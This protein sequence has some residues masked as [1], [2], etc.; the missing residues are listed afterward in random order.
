MPVFSKLIAYKIASVNYIYSKSDVFNYFFRI[1]TLPFVF[2]L[3]YTKKGD[4]FLRNIFTYPLQKRQFFTLK[5][6]KK[7]PT[8]A[9][10]PVGGCVD[11]CNIQDFGAAKSAP[12]ADVLWQNYQV[13]SYVLKVN[14]RS[15]KPP[16]R[17]VSPSYIT[18]D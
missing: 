14:Y 3:S 11:M 10:V 17:S 9:L 2:C 4:N 6:Q 18:A 8:K 7:P 5:R 16:H 15:I 1:F 12:K 13:K